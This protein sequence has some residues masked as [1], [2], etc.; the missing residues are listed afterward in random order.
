[1]LDKYETNNSGPASRSA[2]FLSE[3]VDVIRTVTNLN[4]Q[5]SALR[6]FDKFNLLNKRTSFYLNLGAIGFSISQAM[7]IL[8]QALLFYW[9]GKLVAEEGLVRR[10][11]YLLVLLILT[12]RIHTI[13]DGRPVC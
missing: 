3:T 8:L 4:Y 13:V 11:E 12:H 10:A 7:I 2:S 9:G 6:T 5:R 1:M